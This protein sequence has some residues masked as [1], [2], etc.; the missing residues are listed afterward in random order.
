MR[1]AI[2]TAIY[3]KYDPL[4]THPKIPGIDFHC[5]TDDPSLLSRRDWI[6]HLEPSDL[7]PR[8]AAK[9][10]K[11]LGPQSAPLDTYGVTLWVDANCDFISTSFVD[12]ALSDLGADGFAL[13]RN[14]DL[15]CIYA[16]AISCMRGL[17]PDA[18]PVL[19]RQVARY[20]AEGHPENWGLWACSTMARRRSPKL[21]AAMC[22]WWNAI[23][24]WPLHGKPWPFAL[25]RDQIDLPPIIR[26]HGI[27]PHEWPHNQSESPWWR[28][29]PHGMHLGNHLDLRREIEEAAPEGGDWCS[30]DK[31]I[32][33]ASL[34]IALRPQIVVEL[35][36]W[37]GGSAIPIAIALRHL[38][39]GQLVAIDAWS[40]EAS[41]AGQEGVNAAWWQSVG[42]KGHKR[43]R[44]TFMARLE[45]HRIM[46]E[47]CAVVHRWSDEAAV[48]RAIDILHH[49][50]NHGPQVVAD[51]ERWAPAVRVGGLLILN[52]LGWPGGHVRRARDH[53]I[54]LGFVEQYPLGAGIVMQRCRNDR[55]G[56]PIA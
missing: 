31:A 32:Q 13:Y 6:V 53:A 42:D 55:G 29:R 1:V 11:V 14:P 3:G 47:R 34:V 33:L 16:Q 24:S 51:I 5:F 22:E 35:G 27:Q 2:Y 18:A 46:P 21:D 23:V 39:V 48:P 28:R 4:R 50:A 19:L 54:A 38:G 8:L 10:P 20:Y 41:V 40:T 52:D 12:E 30:P 26:K 56:Q 43:A 17:P 49:D 15:D 45:K 36:V 7:P 37:M 9:Q 25:P 44:K